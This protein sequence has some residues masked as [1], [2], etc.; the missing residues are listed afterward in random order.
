MHLLKIIVLFSLVAI[1]SQASRRVGNR[2]VDCL[3]SSHSSL[4]ITSFAITATNW[5]KE[6]REE[7]SRKKQ[8]FNIEISFMKANER[9]EESKEVKER[10]RA[11]KNCVEE[12]REAKWCEAVRLLGS[13]LGN[14]TLEV[15][16]ASNFFSWKKSYLLAVFILILSFLMSSRIALLKTRW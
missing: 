8:F 16:E 15:F 13:R 7:K 5:K 10:K 14:I 11:N 12:R 9:K 2:H 3:S 1:S 4:H 6:E